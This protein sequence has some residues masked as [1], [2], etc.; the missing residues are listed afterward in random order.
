[1]GIP[2]EIL[3]TERFRGRHPGQRSGYFAD[4]K[5]R[6][7]GSSLELQGLCK[8]G[9]EFPVEISLSPLETAEG[10]CISKGFLGSNPKIKR[11]LLMRSR[12]LRMRNIGGLDCAPKIAPNR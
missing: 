8:D 6:S 5:V 3:V 11:P 4:P 9:T 12:K 10:L 2:V 7:M 1:V